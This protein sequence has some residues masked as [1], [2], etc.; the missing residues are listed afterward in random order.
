MIEQG[1]VAGS[2]TITSHWT[3]A[4][5]TERGAGGRRRLPSASRLLPCLPSHVCILPTTSSTT[6]GLRQLREPGVVWHCAAPN[7]TSKEANA[8]NC[9]AV[10]GMTP[11][12]WGRRGS[13]TTPR[14]TATWHLD[15]LPFSHTLA[16]PP[17]QLRGPCV[18]LLLDVCRC[19]R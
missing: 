12:E 11:S 1:R 19:L 4:R 8:T 15:T 9:G 18:V 2:Y 6:A 10:R 14:L 7:P 3:S 17:K 16:L 5:G 13:V